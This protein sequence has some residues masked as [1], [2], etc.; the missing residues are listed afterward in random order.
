MIKKTTCSSPGC[1]APRVSYPS[2]RTA[3]LCSQHEYERVKAIKQRPVV[4]PETGRTVMAGTIHW[5]DSVRRSRAGHWA[6]RAAEVRS[7]REQIGLPI[8][9]VCLVAGMSA[10]EWQAYEDGSRRVSDFARTRLLGAI[11]SLAGALAMEA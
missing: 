11:D 4:D 10:N 3:P 6:A 9:A 1:L 8:S 7:V 5:R 2:G